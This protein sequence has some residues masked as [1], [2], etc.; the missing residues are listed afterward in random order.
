M[1]EECHCE[2]LRIL[3]VSNGNEGNN[4]FLILV[5]PSYPVEKVSCLKLL[6]KVIAR[7]IYLS[8]VDPCKKPLAS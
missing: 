7:S 4:V 2:Y 1:D 6:P 3:K 8:H 5:V